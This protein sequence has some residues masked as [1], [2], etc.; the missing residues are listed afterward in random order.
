LTEKG[1]HCIT[2]T[3]EDPNFFVL[4]D[5]SILLAEIDK[6]EVSTEDKLKAKEQV[7]E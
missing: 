6:S 5:L 1:L 2:R 4:P 3:G 7:L